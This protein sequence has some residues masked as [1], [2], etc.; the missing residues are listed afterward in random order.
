MSGGIKTQ[1]RLSKKEKLLILVNGI[2][3]EQILEFKQYQ[4]SLSVSHLPVFC[5]G[6]IFRQS[7]PQSTND[8]PT[9]LGLTN[10]R[11]QQTQI[12]ESTFSLNALN[13]LA[14]VLEKALIGLA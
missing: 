4:N 9:V 3:Q 13:A 12:E 1:T 7:L 2:F 6:F 8:D 10:P 14:A 5:V 11:S